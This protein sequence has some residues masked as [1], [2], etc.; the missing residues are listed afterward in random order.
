MK[1]ILVLLFF[2]LLILTSC[3]DTSPEQIEKLKRGM[4]QQ[5]VKTLLGEPYTQEFRT[6]GCVL[7]YTYRADLYR[8]HLSVFI[9]ND[10]VTHWY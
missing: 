2:I 3:N 1:K 6:D 5:E 7:R 9:E 10:Q 8:H 4:S